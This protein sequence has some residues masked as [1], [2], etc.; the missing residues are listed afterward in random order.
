M[1]RYAWTILALAALACAGGVWLVRPGSVRPVT[2]GIVQFTANNADT[3]EGFKEGLASLGYAEGANVRYVAPPPASS[4]EEL[5]ARLAE[6]LAAKPDLLFV[7]STPAAL[8]ARKATEGMGL[9]VVF[10]PVNDPVASGVVKN[11]QRPEA[12][13]TGVRLAPSDG[14]RLQSL[15]SIKPTVRA[16]CVPFDAKD[17]SARESLRRIQE[18]AAS[19]GVDILARPIGEDRAEEALAGLVPPGADAVFLPRDGL[20]MSLFREFSRI[21]EM[22]GIPMS[23]PRLDQVEKGV[24]TGYGFAGRE[25]GRQAAGMAQRLLS[26]EPVSGVPVEIAQDYLFI[27]LGTARA[28]GMDVPEQVLRQARYVFRPGK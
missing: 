9:P 24:L 7:S 21:A 25:V 8:A 3:V 16:V 17:E 22:R 28:L 23:T 12:N 13:L 14:R 15:L 20:A 6:V 18:A 1:R 19:L 5:D 4:R 27:N 10:A 26:G 2:I 11:P